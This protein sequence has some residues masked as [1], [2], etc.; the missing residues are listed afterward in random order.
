[1]SVPGIIYSTVAN[2]C[3]RCHN[4]R[5]FENNNPY[6]FTNG[7]KMKDSCSECHLK[8]EREPGFFYGAMYVSYGL[9][10]GI[11]IVWF[12]ADVVW[13][14]LSPMNLALL[15]ISTM[16]LFFPVVFRT[17]RLIWLNFFVKFDGKYH[18]HKDR[19]LQKKNFIH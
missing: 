17:A 12:F 6:S 13:L 1:M 9:M 5:V 3:P 11:F 10:A 4:G 7:L 2:K 14:H 18:S 19:H 16:L 15:I 8:Y